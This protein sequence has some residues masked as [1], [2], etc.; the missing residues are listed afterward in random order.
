MVPRNA[1]LYNL[2]IG[3]F[4]SIATGQE[5]TLGTVTATYYANGASGSVSGSATYDATGQTWVW[6]QIPAAVMNADLVGLSFSITG[7]MPVFHLLSTEVST[8]LSS[9]VA[10]GS[11]STTSF[12]GD[13]S[14]SSQG[15]FYVGSVLLFTSGSLSGMARRISGYDGVTK[16]L[17]FATAWPTVPS[18]PDTFIIMGRIE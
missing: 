8:Y 5:V 9:S 18:L 10:S 12:T 6:N 13:T 3:R 7:C 16:V 11:I 15:G 2:P 17:T 1:N 14:L 4:V